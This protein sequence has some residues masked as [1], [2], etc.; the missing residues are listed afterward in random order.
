[1]LFHRKSRQKSGQVLHDSKSLYPVLY[2]TDHLKD[3]KVELVQKEVESLWELSQVAHSFSEVLDKADHFQDQL[4]NFGQ[5]FSDINQAAGQFAEVRGTITQTVSE[6]EVR[7]EDLKNTS[8]EIEQTFSGMEQTFGQLQNAIK[9]IQKCMERIVSIAD[10]TNILAI[11]ATI[12]AAR[13]GDAGKGFAV[14]ASEVKELADEIK[15]L[16][17]EVDQGVQNVSEGAS[18]LN[19]NI[20]ASGQA[21]GQGTGIVESTGSSF[22]EITAAAEGAT[23]VQSQISEVIDHS[24]SELQ[25]LCRFFDDMRLQYQEV[26]KH[27]NRASNLGT[28]KSAMFE[29]IDNMLSQIPPIIQDPNPNQD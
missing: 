3:Y 23:T 9:S 26:V 1:M 12:E 18:L 17:G 19:Q 22:R 2:V 6:A 20:S 13:A 28:T 25:E 4:Q 21:L 10:Q 5:T 29:D 11:N 7:V 24:Q 8:L 15:E 27:I 16:A 14:V